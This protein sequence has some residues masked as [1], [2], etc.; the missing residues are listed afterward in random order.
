MLYC[1]RCQE[2]GAKSNRRDL[3]GW[4]ISHAPLLTSKIDSSPSAASWHEAPI[5]EAQWLH[6]HCS[7]F[8]PQKLAL[9]SKAAAASPENTCSRRRQ[10]SHPRPKR[11]RGKNIQ[12][13]A[14]HLEKIYLIG[15]WA[16][17]RGDSSLAA[18]GECV[19][20]FCSWRFW[21]DLLL[22]PT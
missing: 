3:G 8:P 19:N 21:P 14:Q 9:Q 10:A 5:V 20:R 4:Q 18:G 12:I 1:P 7:P 16:I 2:K 17:C 6:S 11:R 13:F 22:A 15:N